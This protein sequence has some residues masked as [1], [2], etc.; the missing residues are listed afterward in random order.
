MHYLSHFRINHSI[1]H[2]KKWL[3]S[4][5]NMVGYE[6]PPSSSRGLVFC[7]EELQKNWWQ[8]DLF[9]FF[10]LTNQQK[11]AFNSHP[12][13]EIEYSS[14]LFIFLPLKEKLPIKPNSCFS[15][16]AK[17]LKTKKEPFLIFLLSIL[18]KKSNDQKI[19]GPNTMLYKLL[20]FFL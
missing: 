19:H 17:K 18:N 1:Y 5:E 7:R 11:G 10:C 6:I 3:Y 2:D 9:F 13:V 4:L 8:F 20:N 14:C 15:F 12:R 16:F